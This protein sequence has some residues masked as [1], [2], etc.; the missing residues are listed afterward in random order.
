MTHVLS[1]IFDLFCIQFIC[2]FILKYVCIH[3]MYVQ[4][5]D[6]PAVHPNNDGKK[7]DF[8]YAVTSK[9]KERSFPFQVVTKVNLSE[10]SNY[11]SWVC[12]SHCFLGYGISKRNQ[13]HVYLSHLS[14]LSNSCKCLS[15]CFNYLCKRR[16]AYNN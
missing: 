16:N 10:Q 6:F 12:P 4:V 14:E 11:D 5:C 2:D 15:H 3:V 7:C 13:K 1:D 9:T 8:T